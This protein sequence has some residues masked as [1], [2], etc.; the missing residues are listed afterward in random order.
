[1]VYNYYNF[2]TLSNKIVIKLNLMLFL[3]MQQKRTNMIH[4]DS[5]W[6]SYGSG[7][8]FYVVRQIQPWSGNTKNRDT[9]LL[10][11][12]LNIPAYESLLGN[13]VIGAS[14]EGFVAENI[15]LQGW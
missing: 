3:I 9:G 6:T 2:I 7:R 14:W 5:K 15:I 1:M 13:P 4:W 10:H 8:D 11:K 12:L